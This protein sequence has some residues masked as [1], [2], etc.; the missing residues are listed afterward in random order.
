MCGPKAG[1][2]VVNVPVAARV[3]E[4]TAVLFDLDGVLVPTARLHMAAWQRL[5][6]ECFAERGLEPA[7]GDRDY[8]A[9]VDGRPRYD[10]VDAVL[11][12]RGL[13]LPS[14]AAGD[15]KQAGTVCGLG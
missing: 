1:G 7:Y 10:G 6:D 14:G 9:L 8:Y 12:S 15:D 11:R 2:P 5:F 4:S 3:A 13:E